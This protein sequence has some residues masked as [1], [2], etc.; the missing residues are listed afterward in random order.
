MQ[1][2]A[3]AVEQNAI[4]LLEA[5]HE[6]VTDL[7]NKFEK[8]TSNARK[9][10]IVEKICS[11]LTIHAKV[12]EKIFYPRVKEALEDSELIP[13]AIV[14]HATLK[15]LISQI[16]DEEQDGEIFDAKVKVLSE[17]V[18]HHV[19]EEEGEIFPKAKKTKLDM[20]EMG[21]EILE[22]KDQLQEGQFQEEEAEES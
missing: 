6:E 11:E 1:R 18:K 19:K 4:K 12:E 20:D 17:Y 2:Q 3:K 14:E 15:S 8:S 13:E 5:D 9:K 10:E 7:F 21:M 22:M 16:E